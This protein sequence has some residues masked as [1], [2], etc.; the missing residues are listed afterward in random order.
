MPLHLLRWT[1]KYIEQMATEDKIKLVFKGILL[2]ITFIVCMLSAMGIDSIYDQGYFFIDVILCA[3]LIYTCYKTIN[4][5]ELDIL[6]LN[7]YL[8]SKLE[9]DDEW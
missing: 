1:T 9:E 4:E 8:G 2:Y 5:E 3:G 7:K 6:T